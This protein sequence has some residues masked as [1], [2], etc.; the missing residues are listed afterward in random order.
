MQLIKISLSLSL[1]LSLSFLPAADI[2]AEKKKKTSPLRNSVEF[3]QS[4]KTDGIV[5]IEPPTETEVSLS[6]EDKKVLA[7]ASAFTQ[8]INKTRYGS[9][10]SVYSSIFSVLFSIL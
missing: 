5:Q 9:S 1:S 2:D 8:A 3:H 7:S 6:P 4:D 10:F